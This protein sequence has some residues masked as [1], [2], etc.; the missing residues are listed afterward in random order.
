MNKILKDKEKCIRLWFFLI[1]TARRA[2]CIGG[3]S[4]G[5]IAGARRTGRAIKCALK[6]GKNLLRHE[7]AIS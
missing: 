4:S 6:L 7:A 5:Q 1:T 3:S 2:G